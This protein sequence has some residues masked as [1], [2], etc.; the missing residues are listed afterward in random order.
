MGCNYYLRPIGFEEIE[1]INR[2]IEH[3]LEFITNNYKAEINNVIKKGCKVSPLYEE[4]LELPKTSDIFTQMQWEVEVPEIHVC[5][6]SLGWNPCF[7]VNKMFKTY[8]E[9]LE[10]YTKNQDVFTLINEYNE[11]INIE[12]FKEDL[13]YFKERAKSENQRISNCVYQYYKDMDGFD[14]ID[15]DFS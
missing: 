2:K 12:K 5:K 6:M 7:Q 4:L 1:S 11:F 8:K 3:D 9:F 14:W 10:F 15:R 13:Q